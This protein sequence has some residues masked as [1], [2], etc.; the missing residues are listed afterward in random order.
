M[1]HRPLLWSERDLNP[2]PLRPPA[3]GCHHHGNEA[4]SGQQN[5]G[6]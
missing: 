1:I 4:D 2:R 3:V 6:E 5:E